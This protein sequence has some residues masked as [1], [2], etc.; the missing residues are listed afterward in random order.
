LD[1]F[2]TRCHGP[3]MRTLRIALPVLLFGYATAASAAPEKH[4]NSVALSVSPLHL[5]FPVFEVT[6]ELLVSP[7][8]SVA[9]VAGAGTISVE[10]TESGET[11]SDKFTVYEVGAQGRYYFYGTAQEGALAGLELMYAHVSGETERAT[12]VGNGLGV[13]PI[14]GYKW[15]WD[16]GFF[17]DLNGGVLFLAVQA[18]ATDGQ[19]TSSDEASSL[20]PNLNFNLGLSF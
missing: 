3:G 11:S 14:I 9:L 6:A 13:G 7:Q 17:I 2:L 10:T 15:V 18:E 4:E 8:F 16:S 1:T 19:T 20:Q 5:A 12:G